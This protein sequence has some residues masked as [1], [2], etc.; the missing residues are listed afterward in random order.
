[1][2]RKNKN[3][4]FLTI[5]KNMFEDGKRKFRRKRTRYQQ[6]CVILLG[7]FAASGI[8]GGGGLD[9]IAVIMKFKDY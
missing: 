2:D 8:G 6:L 1:M 5:S 9:H 7:C 4:A 3:R